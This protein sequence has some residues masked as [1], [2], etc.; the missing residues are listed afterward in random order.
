MI[1]GWWLLGSAVLNGHVELAWIV[2]WGLLL[3]SEVPLQLFSSYLQGVFAIEVGTLIKKRLMFGALSLDP[4]SLKKNGTG[5]ILSKVI[6]AESLESVATDGGLL[7][8]LCVFEGVM[9]LAILLIGASG[10]LHFELFVLFMFV[11]G[12]V[13]RKQYKYRENWTKL[14]LSMSNDLI[15]KMTGHRT[16]L[17]QQDTGDWHKEEDIK[18]NEY[19]SIS[20]KMDKSM[21]S[22]LSIAPRL[23]LCVGFIGLIPA[24]LD[25]IHSSALIAISLG[26]IL[27]IYRAI[28]RGLGAY[29]NLATVTIAWQRISEIFNQKNGE[30]KS[31]ITL[32]NLKINHKV[33][34]NKSIIKKNKVNDNLL[35]NL[36]NVTF[37]Y[38]MNSQAI[39]K[40]CS[41]SI[42]HGDL[43]LLEGHSGSGKSTLASL[44]SGVK[45]QQ[46]GAI[47]L[48]GLDIY[49]L[50]HNIW[51]TK[52]V[53]SPQFHENHI[54]T[55]TFL[56]NLL[57][58]RHWPPSFY[59][60][61]EAHEICTELGLDSLISK[62]PGGMMQIIGETGW[63]L[64]HGEKSRLFIA[65][66]LLQKAEL[67]V[68][69][70]NF[71]ALDPET[72]KLSI[73]C[74]ASR[75][76]SLLVIAHP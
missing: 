29:D 7:S 36:D 69:D 59:L 49:T 72:M 63:Q 51:R 33:I 54:I 16:R 20:E 19:I 56:F 71:G 75:A 73:K 65:R 4:Q 34:T 5:E 38:K 57:M 64:S 24:F 27:L 67:I 11:L 26:G 13:I 28:L 62:M 17:I 48:S 25:P 8:V 22:L 6:D 21:S 61:Q 47:L 42:Y 2:A 66:T 10:W 15:E 30:L 45:K 31:K 52:V 53:I 3:L 12:F 39:L 43:I 70:E 58:G 1:L 9:A 18:L 74:V 76:S 68:L 32:D 55:E 50:G 23:W 41:F 35:L 60:V 40:D 44:I 37:S 46:S 14:R